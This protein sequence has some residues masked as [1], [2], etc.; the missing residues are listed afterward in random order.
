MYTNHSVCMH[1]H[2]SVCM[3]MILL[4]LFLAL[5]TSIYPSIIFYHTSIWK[6]TW[7]LKICFPL[8]CVFHWKRVNQGHL[9]RVQQFIKYFSVS[10]ICIYTFYYSLF[11][12]YIVNNA[13]HNEVLMWCTMIHILKAVWNLFI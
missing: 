8:L 11:S 7:R 1:T 6:L 12:I 2:S 3:L 5:Y 9:F 10:T 4:F 13:T